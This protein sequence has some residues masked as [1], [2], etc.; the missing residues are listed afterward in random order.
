MLPVGKLDEVEN[1]EDGRNYRLKHF[2]L[3]VIINKQLLLHLVGC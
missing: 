2:E 1:P 3:I